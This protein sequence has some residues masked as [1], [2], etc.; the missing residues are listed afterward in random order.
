MEQLIEFIKT[1]GWQLTLIAVAG[2][3][4]LGVL[5]YCKV[6]DKFEEKTRHFLYLLISVGLSIIGSVIYLACI[7]QLDAAF[8]FT[9]ATVVFG[10]NQVAYTIYDTT[11]LRD[12]LSQL[13]DKI[14][15][16]FAKKQEED[17]KNP[18]EEVGSEPEPI[19]PTIVPIPIA[20]TGLVYNGSEQVAVASTEFYTVIDGSAINAGEY[21]ATVTLID[22]TK[23]VWEAE[24]NGKVAFNIEKATYDMS[25]VSFPDT[26]ITYDGAAHSIFISGD[27]PENVTVSYNNNNHTDI[28]SYEIVASFLGDELNYNKIEDMKATLTIEKA[29][30]K[31]TTIVDTSKN[32]YSNSDFPEITISEDSTPGIIAWEANQKLQVGTNKYNWKFTPNSENYYTAIGTSTFTVIEAE[33]NN[34]S[35][36]IYFND[37]TSTEMKVHLPALGKATFNING[38]E[39]YTIKIES[40]YGVTATSIIELM[41]YV[42]DNERPFLPIAD[43]Y[44]TEFDIDKQPSYFVINCTPDQYNYKKLLERKWESDEVTFSTKLTKEFTY[45]MIITSSEGKTVTVY[46]EQD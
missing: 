12:L 10:A 35:N 34:I 13:W 38:V 29:F 15:E 42:K 5:K 8:I 11:P 26:T 33:E 19:E 6:F 30:P 16:F 31:I 1:Y 17:N 24:F 14:V 43:D 7:H 25:G 39:D 21:E 20:I 23:Y 27:L 44:T 41:Y 3:I 45:K 36:T 40:N 9:F 28:G 22:T 18:S 37:D 46:L 2:V 32:I 4:L